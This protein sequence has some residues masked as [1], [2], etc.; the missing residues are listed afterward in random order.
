MGRRLIA[1]DDLVTK[2]ISEFT[3]AMRYPLTLLKIDTINK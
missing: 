3:I 2:D 1:K